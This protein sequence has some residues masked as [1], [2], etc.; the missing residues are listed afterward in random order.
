M[1][2]IVSLPRDD[3]AARSYELFRIATRTSVPPTN[4]EE[5]KRK[6]CRLALR[7][8]YRPEIPSPPVE[9]ALE[10]FNFLDHHFDLAAGGDEKFDE[11]IQSALCALASASD[12]LMNNALKHFDLRKPSFVNGIRRVLQ[13]HEPLRLR[14]AVLSFLPRIANVW[15]DPTHSIMDPNDMEGFCK[16]WASAIDK[17]GVT[18]TTRASSLTVLFYMINSPHSRPYIVASKWGL[19]EYFIAHPDD[20]EPFERCLRNPE[21]VDGIS[22]GGGEYAAGLWSKILLLRYGWLGDEVRSRFREKMRDVLRKDIE[23]YKSMIGLKWK[24]AENKLTQFTTWSMDPEAIDLREEVASHKGAMKF[25][26][27]LKGGYRL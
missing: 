26:E 20:S 18:D 19:L 21:V 9:D 13:D 1:E 6:V 8:A 16:D 12:P 4:A 14:K 11:P 24:E 2:L 3:V 22:S 17:I 15:F 27:S 25:L 23:G 10:I 7:G 5:I